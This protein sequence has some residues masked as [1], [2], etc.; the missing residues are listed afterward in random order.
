MDSVASQSREF[1]EYDVGRHTF[2]DPFSFYLHM[3]GKYNNTIHFVIASNPR[4]K[5]SFFSLRSTQDDDERN[6]F[7]EHT[8][9]T[10]KE[11]E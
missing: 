6:L 9:K 3:P 11:N 7:G 5:E 4:R 1:Q 8:M 10:N 2:A